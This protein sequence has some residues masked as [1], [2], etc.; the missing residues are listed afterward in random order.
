[1]KSIKQ[2]IQERLVLRKSGNNGE[3][4]FDMLFDALNNMKHSGLRLADIWLPDK[5]PVLPELEDEKRVAGWQITALYCRINEKGE[6]VISM[7]VAQKHP[8]YD[9]TF[10][11]LTPENLHKV[12]SDEDLEKIY[13][14]AL[15]YS[16]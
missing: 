2:H 13:K 8:P 14:E 15:E 9:N 10:V 5:R 16:R 12:F 11:R 6:D 7:N 1:M 4:T 3:I